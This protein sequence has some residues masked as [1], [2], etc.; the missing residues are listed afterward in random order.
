MLYPRARL[1][2]NYA[3]IALR[4]YYLELR[5]IMISDYLQYEMVVMHY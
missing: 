3:I 4:I 1:R 5:Q 2:A